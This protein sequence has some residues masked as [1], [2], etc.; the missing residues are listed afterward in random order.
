MINISNEISHLNRQSDAFKKT[1]LSNGFQNNPVVEVSGVS[2]KISKNGAL[3]S[4]LFDM[5]DKFIRDEYISPY[6]GEVVDEKG[7]L[8]EQPGRYL[9]FQK[10]NEYIFEK[11]AKNMVR[12]AE[13]GGVV[14]D[15]NEVIDELKKNNR[16]IS[17]LNFD[18]QDRLSKLPGG[19][20][21]RN[22][23]ESD[24]DDFTDMFIAA[25][26][27]GLATKP[28]I[29]LA[30]DVAI[31][32]DP[33]HANTLWADEAEIF[34]ADWDFEKNGSATPYYQPSEF[35]LRL[36]ESIRVKLDER[37]ARVPLGKEVMTNWLLHPRRG[38]I[39]ADQTLLEIVSRTVDLQ[40]NK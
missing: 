6:E 16:M 25:K 4:G 8:K 17:G 27:G 38:L 10:Y 9:N 37:G 13:D 22:L 1:I 12:H 24:L 11:A 40:N 29:S 19:N 32:K 33:M 3:L 18:N 35:N 26:E 14:L 15:E 5:A 36:G 23:T 7:F 20:V 2:E 30:F 28:I 21:F 39:F 34:P 31:R